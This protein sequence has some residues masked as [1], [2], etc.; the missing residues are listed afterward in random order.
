MLV[1]AFIQD[2]KLMVIHTFDIYSLEAIVNL[3]RAQQVMYAVS[4]KQRSQTLCH[5]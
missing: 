1:I 3:S 5:F 4:E 2:I